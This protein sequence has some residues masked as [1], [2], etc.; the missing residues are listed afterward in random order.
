[1]GTVGTTNQPA[2]VRVR[3]PMGF[4]IPISGKLA[5]VTL[6]LLLAA[7]VPIALKT[8]GL[9]LETSGKREEEGNR[10]Q[11][12]SRAAE[13]NGL[14]ESYVDKLSI[15]GTLRMK[16]FTD[17]T[18]NQ[19]T[20]AS[21]VIL[22]RDKEIV[23]FAV[24]TRLVNSNKFEAMN[25]YLDLRYLKGY[26]VD[27]SYLDTLNREKPFP[28][29]MVFAGAPVMR[30][31]SLSGGAPLFSM[32]VPIAKDSLGR[33]THI[34]VADLPMSVLQR[35]F[36]KATERTVYLVDKDGTVL[37]H[38]D[39]KLVIDGAS[40]ASL[41][42]VKTAMASKVAQGQLR[43]QLPKKKDFVIAAYVRCLFDL[44]VISEAP[45]RVILE[46]AKMMQREVYYI[47]G[48]VVSL[49]FLAVFIFSLTLTKPIERLVAIAGE[50]ARGNFNVS[51]TRGI[52]SK[53]E[54]EML[55]WAFDGMT[56]GL[57]E[58]DKVKNLFNKFHGSSVT[59]NL[60]QSGEVSLGG[61][62]KKVCVFFSDIRGFTSFSETRTP[63]AVVSMLNEYFTVMVKIINDNGGVVDKFIGDAIMAVW[64]TPQTTGDDPFNA[65]KACLEMRVGLLQLNER[66]IAR[67]EEP[68][69]IGM[70]LH[71]GDTI[72]GTVG[73]EDR[74]EFTVIG[75]TVNMASRIES[76]TKAFGTDLLL[77]EDLAKNVEGRVILEEAGSAEV[78]G[79]TEPLKFYKVRGLIMPDGSRQEIRT[80][81]SD[82][83]AEKADKVKVVH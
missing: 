19:A 55:A 50:V 20:S 36:G 33:V 43:Y 1:M 42:I 37:A 70:G 46:P 6:L 28:V 60:L 53:D 16:E 58:R 81:Y 22:Q 59:E 80:I 63:E 79:K 17:G 69:K 39:E 18:A 11:A 34:A 7:A 29:E 51:A 48:I 35:G 14:L 73:S 64:G 65:V 76:S 54:V 44:V 4:F 10:S 49:G 74:M 61:M 82:Y 45:E 8:T 38:P 41:P 3:A 71:Y 66:R 78:K 68:I 32:G 56:E 13:I 62:K 21:N 83:E 30:N 9:F 27:G 52:K 23:S 15:I 47:A 77:S 12:G 24:I 31:R 5:A 67:G 2:N 26:K 40:L 25:R 72:S 75:D 57:R